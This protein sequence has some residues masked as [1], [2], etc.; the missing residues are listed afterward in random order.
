[1]LRLRGFSSSDDGGVSN[2]KRRKTSK[3]TRRILER[4]IVNGVVTVMIG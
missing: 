2:S 1:M 3:F 4:S